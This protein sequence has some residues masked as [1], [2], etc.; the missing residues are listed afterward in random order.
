MLG[1]LNLF[2]PKQFIGGCTNDILPLKKYVEN[3]KEIYLRPRSP[4]SVAVVLQL[5]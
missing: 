5:L 3:A 2:P 4:S 1:G